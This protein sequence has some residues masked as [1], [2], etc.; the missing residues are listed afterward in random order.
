M[1]SGFRSRCAMGG[2]CECRWHTAITT[3]RVHCSTSDSGTRVPA[4]RNADNF[5]AT[6]PF[7]HSSS[8]M[9]NVTVSWSSR[10]SDAMYLT[11]FLWGG[12]FDCASA[13]QPRQHAP[14]TQAGTP[15]R[16]CTEVKPGS[17]SHPPGFR[18]PCCI[19]ATTTSRSKMVST[20]APSRNEL[21]AMPDSMTA[22]C[23]KRG[24]RRTGRTPPRRR[25]L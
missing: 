6:V 23:G 21:L 18:S 19:M 13:P 15:A 9:S 2:D 24:T 16:K 25:F 11:I 22:S 1:F 14:S 4:S 12:S 3:S 5:A 20:T 10:T 17:S 7:G 8:R